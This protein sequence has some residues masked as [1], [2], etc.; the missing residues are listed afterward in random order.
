MTCHLPAIDFDSS[1]LLK[2]PQNTSTR[3]LFI[4]RHAPEAPAHICRSFPGD[5]GYPAYYHRMWRTLSDLGYAV[6]SSTQCHSLLGAVGNVD[7]VFSLYNRM[8][9]SNP[10][11]WVSSTCEFMRLPYIGAPPNVRAVA[12]DKWLSKIVARSAGLPVAEGMVYADAQALANPPAFDGPYFV[13]NR[14]GAASEGVTDES[15]QDTWEGAARV[16]EGLLARGITVLVEQYAPGLDITVP[17][18]GGAHPMVLGVVHPR[19]DKVGGIITE[20][21]KRGDPLGYEMFDAG[22]HAKALA[23]D[24]A[25]L[26]ATLGAM[27]YYRLDYRFDPKTGKRTFLEFNICCYI[28]RNGAITLAG[29]QHGL[30]LHDI[31]GHVMEYSLVRQK[32]PVDSRSWVL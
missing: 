32:R 18:L 22:I 29:E 31:L 19:S 26:W 8:S 27:D 21:L 11:L 28:G 17:V 10:E 5:G 1:L 16:A 6:T 14:F 13:K 7:L 30:S 25:A 24:A 15:V 3:I 9:V 2:T 23:Q 20:D 12:E 4:A